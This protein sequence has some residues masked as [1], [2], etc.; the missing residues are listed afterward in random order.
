M[1][2]SKTFWCTTSSRKISRSKKHSNSKQIF[3][4]AFA[5]VSLAAFGSQAN[6]QTT[7]ISDNFT[8]GSQY[9]SAVAIAPATGPQPDGTNLPGGSYQLESQGTD[10]SRIFT[11]DGDPGATQNI[12]GTVAN[13]WYSHNLDAGAIS[14][15]STNSYVEPNTFNFAVTIN[16]SVGGSTGGS[17]LGFFTAVSAS[18]YGAGGAFLGLTL[19]SSGNLG[20][21]ST[22]GS[23]LIDAAGTG[24]F[25][26]N[27]FTTLSY[28]LAFNTTTDVATFSNIVLNGASVSGSYNTGALDPNSINY[29][30]FQA[31]GG[32]NIAISKFVLTGVTAIPEPS[33][34]ALLAT[35]AL[36][37]GTFRYRRRQQTDL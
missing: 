36:A 22:S 28:Q 15:T 20:Y 34:Y 16:P 24:I 14:L 26:S 1:K 31:G 12:I 18:N 5:G 32:E 17:A 29:A 30:G 10:N 2:K 21:F 37:F 25:D 4:F 23:G 35:G 19:D 6:A 33:T 11:W 27:G 13:Y 3:G 7:I 9:G 8:S